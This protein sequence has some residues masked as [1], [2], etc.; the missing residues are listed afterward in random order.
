MVGRI[1]E[2]ERMVGHAQLITVA[3]RSR[4]KMVELGTLVTMRDADGVEGTYTIRG[5]VEANSSAHII[6]NACPLGQTV[7]GRRVGET[8]PVV[9]P[10]GLYQVTIVAV[11]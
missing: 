10:A 7:L 8:V 5:S 2:L 3:S 6:S 11:H 4:R 9:S 1:Q